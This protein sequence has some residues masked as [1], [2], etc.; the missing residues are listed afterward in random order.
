M[1][2]V[3]TWSKLSK[4]GYDAPWIECWPQPPNLHDQDRVY[5]IL[6]SSYLTSNFN[7][8]GLRAG[9]WRQEG[10]RVDAL[11]DH[12]AKA[13]NNHEQFEMDDSF[14]LSIIQVLQ[15]PRGSGG[16]RRLKPGHQKI[17][18]EV[19]LL[20]HYEANVPFRPCGFKE[21]SR[22][23]PAPSLYEYQ[24]LLVDAHRAYR[25]KSFGPPL[26]KQLIL[27]HK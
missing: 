3:L 9:E 16:K 2:T 23:S 13:L 7:G 27:L 1:W 10:L 14:Q 20:L 15:A 19:T 12:L 26:P 24:I 18:K 5:F 25:V 8:W 21:L 22:F 11:L 4:T 6:S 17:Q